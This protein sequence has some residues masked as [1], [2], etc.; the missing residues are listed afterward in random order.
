MC[1]L[2]TSEEKLSFAPDKKVQSGVT[3]QCLKDFA[4]VISGSD[5]H[6]GA[7]SCHCQHPHCIFW[8]WLQQ[9]KNTPHEFPSSWS[10]S[11]VHIKEQNKMHK[12]LETMYPKFKNFTQIEN[13]QQLLR[14]VATS[15]TL[16]K[17]IILAVLHS[18]E[19][20]VLA[21]QIRLT[22]SAWAWK[23]VGG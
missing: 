14:T 10:T 22:A 5:K 3:M 11:C 4:K 7:F 17:A 9:N 1:P 20:C 13:V 8:I 19:T 2:Q 15:L 12:S 16:I 21:P 6:T 23:R 18:Q